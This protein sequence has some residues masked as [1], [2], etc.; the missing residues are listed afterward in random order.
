[1]KPV[2]KRILAVLLLFALTV[3]ICT[4]IVDI[5]DRQ[6][7]FAAVT[8]QAVAYPDGFVET[9]FAGRT[10]ALK[11]LVDKSGLSADADFAD[12]VKTA[13][14]ELYQLAR[15]VLSGEVGWSDEVCATRVRAVFD[16]LLELDNQV[17]AQKE[18]PDLTAE[19][20]F[21]AFGAS[22]LWD[23]MD[24]YDTKRLSTQEMSEG[25]SVIKDI[26][27]TENADEYQLL[28]IYYPAGEVEKCPVIINIHG[29]GLM[30]GDKDMNRIYASRLA[31]KGYIVIVVNYHLCPE[32]LYDAQ[33]RDLMTAY[34]W[35]AE[36]GEAYNCDL[37]NVY[38]VGDSAGGQLAFYTSIV[39]TSEELRTLY[40]A[41]ETG[42]TFN[43]TGLISGM[44]DMKSGVNSILIS[45][46]LGYAYTESPY[47]DVLQPEEVIDKGTLPPSYIVTSA[48]DFL[49]PASVQLDELLTEKGIEHQFHDWELTINRSSGH[50][51]SVAYPDL[52]ESRITIDEML[53]FFE[54]H[55]R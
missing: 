24:F 43:A 12:K 11:T 36:H 13:F 4:E 38:L 5:C 41:P 25:V 6:A 54:S 45:C 21:V 42:L 3:P 48:K 8:Q 10:E 39:N 46:M 51:T 30:Y 34:K 18:V 40:R 7:A 19:D 31:E 53:A 17:Q 1:M 29:G 37:D 49:R 23:F 44:Y 9:E 47:Y 14:T 35:V 2:V 50:I 28:D 33:V 26:P 15:D 22:I 52:E 55:R 20:G 27:Y 16:L 32:V